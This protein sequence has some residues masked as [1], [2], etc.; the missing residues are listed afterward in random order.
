MYKNLVGIS[1]KGY[2]LVPFLSF[3][4]LIS[5]CGPNAER[6]VER[7]SIQLPN[8]VLILADDLGYG[9]LGSYGQEIIETPNIDKLAETGM[10]FTQ[11]YSGAPVCA[12]ARCMLLTGQHSGH[13]FVR[14]NDEWGSRGAVWNYDSMFVN[15][16]LEG[17]RPLPDSI[18]TIAQLL[19]TKGYKTALVGKWGLGGPLT[20][21]IPNT[22][23]FDFFYGYNCQR[24]A[25]TYFPLHLWRNRE[26]VLLNNDN[27]AP[28]TKLE[29]GAD[30]YD[31]SSYS[32]FSL[33]DY[34]PDLMMDE[35][36]NFINE[37][38]DNP[39]FLY[40]ATPIPHVPLQSDSLWLKYY[41]E[42][43]GEEEPYIGDK[44]YFPNRTPRATY[45]AMISHLDEQVGQII[46]QLKDQGV[47]DNT[48]I[49]FTSDNGASY[50]GG[51]DTQYFNSNRPFG[52]EYGRGKGF[53]YEGGIRVPMIASWP[54]RIAAG[55]TSDH[56]SAF[57]D[58]LPTM[59]EIADISDIPKNDGI[60]FLP[61]L[62][63]E[64]SQPIHNYLYWE[65]P[66]YNGQVA[67]RKGDFKF[68]WKNLKGEAPRI[69]L[70]NLKEDIA[71]QN[72]LAD[73]Y[74]ELIDEFLSIIKKEHTLAA[75]ERFRIPVLESD[76]SVMKTGN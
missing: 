2:F 32:K 50:A 8:I 34:S 35:V 58:Y 74:P 42:K 24:Q 30:P 49:I 25:H 59:A 31:P 36:E 4:L 75:T 56:I 28:N 1:G 10:R 62:L 26:K 11:H 69:E 20:N 39:F 9:E 15:P 67:I 7:E 68:I 19:Q 52:S 44:G 14:G 53:V 41:K 21:S 46:Q 12:P 63:G 72:D 13:A 43:L 55:S 64:P 65:F 3:A 66:E 27:V 54:G 16:N 22:R 47:F 48:L 60:S 33:N 6:D 51:A 23:G 45:A 76:L 40:Y 70:Y 61:V 18:A 73:S 57:Y 17:Q 37:N 38:S 5:S 29:E 71:E